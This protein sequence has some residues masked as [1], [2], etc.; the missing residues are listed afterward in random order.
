MSEKQR[1]EHWADKA[2]R[3][4]AINPPQPEKRAE[5]YFLNIIV[6]SLEHFQLVAK[7]YPP[8]KY[9]PTEVAEARRMLEALELDAARQ[10]LEK[11]R[12]KMSNATQ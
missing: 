5:W 9:T 11:L 8:G 10:N 7:N 4:L 3:E 12:A 1:E 2:M 6:P